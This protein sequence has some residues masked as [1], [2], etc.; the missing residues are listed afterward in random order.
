MGGNLK[1]NNKKRYILPILF[2]IKPVNIEG[3]FDFG[4]IKKI[5]PVLDLR[6][7]S[8]KRKEASE[9]LTK[10][11]ILEELEEIEKSDI[12]LQKTKFVLEPK[13]IVKESKPKIDPNL[14]EEF[15]FPEV[16]S[17]KYFNA[18]RIKQKKKHSYFKKIPKIFN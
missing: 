17:K 15:Y 2:D 3:N 5:K 10:E 14:L 7:I 8:I 13:K 4:K 12:N 6:S 9:V 1:K 16:A 18:P 11:K